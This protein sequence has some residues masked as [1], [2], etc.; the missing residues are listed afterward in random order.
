MMENSKRINCFV[1]CSLFVLGV[2]ANAS[3]HTMYVDADAS[4]A[5]NGSSWTD[6]Y[7]YLQDALA[8]A[9]SGD[10]IWVAEGIYKPDELGIG[11]LCLLRQRRASLQRCF[12]K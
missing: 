7:T 6:A 2:L 10:E 5:N 3:A 9:T 8:A 12:V 11:G 1:L 4:G